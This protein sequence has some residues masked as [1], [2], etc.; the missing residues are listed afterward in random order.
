[1]TVARHRAVAQGFAHFLMASPHSPNSHVGDYDGIASFDLA[2]E[3][4]RPSLLQG[5]IIANARNCCHSSLILVRAER[6]PGVCV[7]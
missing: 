2:K 1:M 3:E 4:W 6:L 7:P 5:P